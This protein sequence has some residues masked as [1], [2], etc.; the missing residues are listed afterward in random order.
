MNWPH[1]LL[2]RENDENRCI[3]TF[4][5]LSK[6]AP[7]RRLSECR[8]N[9]L[10]LMFRTKLGVSGPPAL[11]GSSKHARTSRVLFGHQGCWNGATTQTLIFN[12]GCKTLPR[13]YT[14]VPKTPRPVLIVLIFGVNNDLICVYSSWFSYRNRCKSHFRVTPWI[15]KRINK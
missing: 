3:L 13:P 4:P 8:R 12:E 10:T 14:R 7:L 9:I 6:L 11:T 1:Q 2:I 5:R 15:W